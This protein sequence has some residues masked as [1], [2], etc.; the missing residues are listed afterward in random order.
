LL[1]AF[2]KRMQGWIPVSVTVARCIRSATRPRRGRPASASAFPGPRASGGRAGRLPGPVA[3][4]LSNS[5]AKQLADVTALFASIRQQPRTTT[6]ISSRQRAAISREGSGRDSSA[7]RVHPKSSSRSRAR[8][9]STERG[10]A[11][12]AGARSWQRVRPCAD[13]RR[14]AAGCAHAVEISIAY[15]ATWAGDFSP[16][17][18]SAEHPAVL[19]AR[20]KMDFGLGDADH[21]RFGRAAP[22]R[23]HLLEPRSVRRQPTLLGRSERHRSAWAVPLEPSRPLDQTPPSGRSWLGG[24]R[25]N[26]R[27][28]TGAFSS[29]RSAPSPKRSP[30]PRLRETRRRNFR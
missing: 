3:E 7:R 11:A 20:A 29:A 8:R 21:R 19:A 4:P 17:A 16:A 15:K 30:A 26:R 10:G 12:T 1:A 9:V 18:A 5:H 22:G 2:S 13:R 28:P 6:E 27:R 14:S 24:A 25:G 23:H